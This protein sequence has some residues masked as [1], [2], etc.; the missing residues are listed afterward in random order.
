MHSP[1]LHFLLCSLCCCHDC[2]RVSLSPFPVTL[3]PQTHSTNHCYDGATQIKLREGIRV[4]MSVSAEANKF[5]TET[6]PFKVVKTDPEHA[7]TL[8]A[9]CECVC[10]CVLSRVV[11]CGCVLTHMYRTTHGWGEGTRG[12]KDIVGQGHPPQDKGCVWGKGGRVCREA[13]FWE[14]VGRSARH[15]LPSSVSAAG[16]HVLSR[17]CVLQCRCC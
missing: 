12:P 17:C 7:A 8:V 6:E 9:A 13:G 1:H 14:A 15:P 4:A 3:F 11:A 16:S 2:R 10:V 5:I